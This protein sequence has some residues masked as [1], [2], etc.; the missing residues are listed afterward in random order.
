MYDLDIYDEYENFE[1]DDSGED[2]FDYNDKLSIAENFKRFSTEW[3]KGMLELNDVFNDTFRTFEEYEE[4]FEDDLADDP[5]FM[6][7]RIA[8]NGYRIFAGMCGN[9]AATIGN[10]LDAASGILNGNN[11]AIQVHAENSSELERT[12][13][14]GD[15]LKL[16]RGV[17]THHGIYAGDGTVIHY[18]QGYD[19]IPEIREVPFSEFAGISKVMLVPESESPLR[20]SAD[21]AVRRARSRLGEQNYN[22][23]YNNCENFVRWCRAGG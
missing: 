17:Y 7:D 18:S 12:Y 9:A 13:K 22:L 14:P 21:E 15:H 8:F 19:E 6:Q 4:A 11:P 1:D 2:L 16:S 10:F 20:F 23:I 5:E 3:K